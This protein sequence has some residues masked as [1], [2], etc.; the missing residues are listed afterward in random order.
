LKKH[1]ILLTLI[2]FGLSVPGCI[3]NYEPIISSITA[4]P[5]PVES[6]GIVTLNCKA[7]DDDDSSMLKE[8]SLSYSWFAADGDIVSENEN[9]T[10]TWTAPEDPGI[11][12]ISCSVSDQ[13]NGLDIATIEVTVE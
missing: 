12:N 8:E 10:A 9:D 2:C 5:N 4:E 3:H 7:S 6:G 13:Y 11:Y 1:F